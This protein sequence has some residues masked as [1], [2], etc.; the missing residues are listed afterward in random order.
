MEKYIKKLCKLGYRYAGQKVDKVYICGE[1][2]DGRCYTADVFY[3]KNNKIFTRHE[4]EK[5]YDNNQIEGILSV[6]RYKL[7]LLLM[8]DAFRKLCKKYPNIRVLKIVYDVKSK[9]IDY[10]ISEEEIPSEIYCENPLKMWY[11]DV[12]EQ[13]EN[14]EAIEEGLSLI[15]ISEP[16]RQFHLSRM[17]SSA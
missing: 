15:H 4:L 3:E 11:E 8:Q 9:K 10:T 17:P 7:L 13:V 16:T 14:K 2:D 5:K 12:K 1:N 6:I